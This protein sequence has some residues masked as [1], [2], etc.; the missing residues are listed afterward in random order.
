MEH[1]TGRISKEGLTV[2]ENVE[3]HLQVVQSGKLKQ[4]HGFIVTELGWQTLEPNTKYRLTASDGRTG[5]IFLAGEVPFGDG[6]PRSIEITF[7]E[8]F[9]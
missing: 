2:A 4:L 1:F 6:T 9:Q 3:V 8:G 7:Y 5:D